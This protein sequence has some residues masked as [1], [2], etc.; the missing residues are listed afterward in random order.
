M[1]SAVSG[2]MSTE[3]GGID[4][5]EW[6]RCNKEDQV[7][8]EVKK[9]VKEGWPNR[10]SVTV[11]VEPYGV[12]PKQSLVE[13]IV[14]APVP[15][16][17]EKLLSFTG[18]CEYYSKFIKDFA[19]KIEPLRELTR[20]GVQIEDTMQYGEVGCDHQEVVEDRSGEEESMPTCDNDVNDTSVASRVKSNFRARCQPAKFKDFV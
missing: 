10:R 9:Y 16:N 17:R 20:K 8:Q 5:N 1:V 14:N 3:F 7:L 2:Y 13:A 12:V 11:E 6:I 18:L 15:D 19:T 4:E